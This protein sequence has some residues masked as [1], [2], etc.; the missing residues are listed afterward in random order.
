VGEFDQGR[1][2]M[3]RQRGSRRTTRGATIRARSVEVFVWFG[4][5]RQTTPS[6]PPIMLNAKG[7][8]SN[9]RS[10]AAFRAY[11]NIAPANNGMG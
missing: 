9:A 2:S 11:S 10:L 7:I 4:G 5:Y 6:S 1:L 3:A 8:T